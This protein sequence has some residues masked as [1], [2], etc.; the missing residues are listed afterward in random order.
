MEE[1]LQ[2]RLALALAGQ[3]SPST[4]LINVE[5]LDTTGDAASELAKM[6][7]TKI[8]MGTRKNPVDFGKVQPN[9]IRN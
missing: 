3:P 1:E 8:G 5:M 4:G 9:R 7:I 6:K 2:R